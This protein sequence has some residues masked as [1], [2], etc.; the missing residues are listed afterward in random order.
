MQACPICQK[1]GFKPTDLSISISSALLRWEELLQHPLS[2]TV[3]AQ[4]QA[5]SEQP[6]F[7][8]KCT[9]CDF[10]RFE[11]TVE[12]T[13]EFYESIV[14]TDYYNADKW[15][16]NRALSDIRA[17]GA[18]RI[19]DVGCGSGLFLEFLKKRLPD[20][21]ELFGFDLNQQLLDELKSRGFG[22]LPNN[23]NLLHETMDGQSLFDVICILQVI[24]HVAEP[25]E[26]LKKF[27][28]FLRPGGFLI[29]TTPNAAG[30]I[31]QF[32]D[33]HT[34]IPP[35]HLTRWTERTYKAMLPQHG[36]KIN[37]IELEPLPDYLWDSYLPGMWDE[38]I[39]PAEIFDPIVRNCGMVSVRERAGL[40]AQEMK[41]A[42]IRFLY[43]VPGH[44]IYVIANLEE[45]NYK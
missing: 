32:T 7:L 22:V 33:S 1:A 15:E 39:W 5:I 13:A 8:F 30:P 25:V 10:S 44:T 37:N 28:C 31:S 3:W 24:E 17:I 42:G 12:G 23:L 41:R 27:L 19:L 26:F 9:E 40:A 14:A 34:E 29:I 4:Y 43:G 20:D 16:F 35:H 36:L 11:P 21:S 45:V 2:E 38:P 18:K 6:V